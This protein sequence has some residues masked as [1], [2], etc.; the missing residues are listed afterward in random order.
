MEQVASVRHY[1]GAGVILFNFTLYISILL[2][3]SPSPLISIHILPHYLYVL[4]ISLSLHNFKRGSAKVGAHCLL[5]Q[6]L[7]SNIVL[8]S[9]T[10]NDEEQTVKFNNKSN[11]GRQCTGRIF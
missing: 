7:P 11:L 4:S 3:L 2:Q 10:E 6:K 5:I 1:I 8:E 9:V